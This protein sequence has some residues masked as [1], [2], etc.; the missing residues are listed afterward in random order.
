MDYGIDLDESYLVR[1]YKPME[2]KDRKHN[3]RRT[4]EAQ[5]EEFSKGTKRRINISIDGDVCDSLDEI[6]DINSKSS[7]IEE[8]LKELLRK[9]GIDF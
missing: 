2:D 6:E 4:K 3:K 8:L 1:E 9:K 7:K 5:K